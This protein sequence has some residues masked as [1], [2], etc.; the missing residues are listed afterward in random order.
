MSSELKNTQQVLEQI[1]AELEAANLPVA[2]AHV[3]TAVELVNAE[4]RRR[5]PARRPRLRAV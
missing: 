1:L 5:T 2:A 4:M 3:S